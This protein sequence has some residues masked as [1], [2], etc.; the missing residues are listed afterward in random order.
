MADEITAFLVKRD[1]DG[2]PVPY[3]VDVLG[4]REK[5]L[6]IKILPT[7]ISS[8][9]GL[10]AP[11][12]DAVQWP[13]D[14]KLRYIREHV[15]EPDFSAM[16]DDELMDMMTQWDLDMLLVTAI[17]NGGPMRSKLGGQKKNPTPRSG[18]SRKK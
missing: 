8:L 15:V 16:T 18:R 4:I 3:E 13:V 7:T 1:E 2:K 9:K 10:S 17:Q 11:E 12:K 5:A 6:K 14:D